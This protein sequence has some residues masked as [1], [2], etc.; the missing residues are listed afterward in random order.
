MKLSLTK[1]KVMKMGLSEKRPDYD[2]HIAGAKLQ[3]S[4]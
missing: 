1:Y 4:V 3:E 2:Y